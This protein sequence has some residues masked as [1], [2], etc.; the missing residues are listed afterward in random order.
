[1]IEFQDNADPPDHPDPLEAQETP[2]RMDHPEVAII[3][4]LLV[5]LLAIKNTAINKDS[6]SVFFIFLK[7]V[8][9]EKHL[10]ILSN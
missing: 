8:W 7:Y 6:I 9:N 4:L 2:E 10:E 3:V 1:M 5:L